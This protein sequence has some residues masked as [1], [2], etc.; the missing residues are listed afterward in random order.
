MLR[1]CV[2]GRYRAGAAP[3]VVLLT[4]ALVGCGKETPPAETANPASPP[5]A[6]PAAAPVASVPG[7]QAS[8]PVTAA[9]PR[10][11]DTQWIGG[12]PY[13][14]FYDRPLEVAAD[15]TLIAT[16]GTAPGAPSM[17]ATSAEPAT[18]TPAPAPMPAATQAAASAGGPVD[19]ATVAPM[20]ILLEEITSLR[21]SL[22]T[23]LT[24]LAEYNKNWETVGTDATALAAIAGVIEQHPGE[25][26]WKSNAA[27]A[28]HL[29]SEINA[30]ASKT[31]RSAYDASKAPYDN[32]VDLLNG[33]APG[34]IE[35]AAE[36]P[37]AD[38]ADRG[39]LMATL[40]SSLNYAKS[41]ITTQ[42]RLAENPA[43]A[44][45]KMTVL[46]TLM[47]VVATPSYDSS[48]EPEYQKF[49][50]T[51]IR[52]AMAGRDAVDGRD[53]E[54]FTAAVAQ[55]QKTCNEC[56]LKYALGGESF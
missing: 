30:N 54:S 1:D 34:G 19:W 37:F 44:K 56:H 13:D 2:S 41:N 53:L 15:Q 11:T 6:Q 29:A 4:A 21:N 32:L 23:K 47:T 45:R 51:F 3:G 8:A 16:A 48:Q 7:P 50:Q 36:A 40:E 14:V 52:A 17:P 33:N 31:G 5:A 20:E 49:T 43:E 22:Q 28:R 24:T 38:Y 35:A 9:S 55:M 42:E 12:I 27:V 46:A 39:V 10:S 26:S 18:A 25:V